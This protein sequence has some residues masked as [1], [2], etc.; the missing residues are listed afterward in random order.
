MRG[1]RRL[2]RA[3]LATVLLG[4]GMVAGVILGCGSGE[5]DFDA[6]SVTD[7]LNDAGAGIVLGEPL[8]VTTEGVEVRAITLDHTEDAAGT[9]GDSAHEHGVAGALVVLEDSEAAEA[10]FARCESAIDFACFRAANTVLRF[11][12]MSPVDQQLMSESVSA[13]ESGS[14]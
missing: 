13:L 1:S 9:E 10:E 5:R 4:I 7:E 2:P 6:A 8:P 12:G 14:G 11:T 3:P